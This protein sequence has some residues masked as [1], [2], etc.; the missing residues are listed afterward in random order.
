M[1]CLDI[2]DCLQQHT[3]II[4][5]R[6]I[7]SITP[8]FWFLLSH[9]ACSCKSSLLSFSVRV[10]CHHR[11]PLVRSTGFHVSTYIYRSQ[12]NSKISPPPHSFSKVCLFLKHKSLS[13]RADNRQT[14][15]ETSHVYIWWE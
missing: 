3:F 14:K 8:Q 7:F 13:V 12:I 11:T 6:S 4:I 1:R 10:T 2:M 9:C 15:G 5:A